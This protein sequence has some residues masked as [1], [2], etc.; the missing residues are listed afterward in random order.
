MVRIETREADQ[1]LGTVLM[2]NV[3]D[4]SGK[5]VLRKGT[6]LAR[7]DLDALVKL[8]RGQV[9]VAVLGE[10]DMRED[11]AALVLGTALCARHLEMTAPSGGR[12]NIKSMVDGVLQVDA[13]R[14]LHLNLVP[15]V[16]AATRG[17]HSVVGPN[18]DTNQVCTLKIVPY[19]VSRHELDRALV[20]AEARPGILEVR[21]FQP[22]RRVVMLLVGEEPVQGWLHDTYVPPTCLR[23]ER[24]GADLVEVSA[25][26]LED[27]S[28][29][30]GLARI[31]EEADLLV[32]ASQ[33]SIAHEEDPILMALRTV[34]A[35]AVV[36]GAPV[37]P[38][39]LLALA[40]LP[41]LPVLCLP[42]CARG[43]RRNVV[44]LVLPRLLLGDR[45]KREDVAAL[46]L[47]GLLKPAERAGDLT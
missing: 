23:L 4:E 6:W 24:L 30:D 45:L 47:G 2:H 39:N 46:G 16:A 3:A 15:G 26:S 5:R 20:L 31:R 8:G 34:G 25:V 44:D 41:G 1:T 35:Q 14:L 33:S 19:A 7:E 27:D 22:G 28:L 38:G 40:Y 42:G 9:L 12:V 29:G 10:D 13:D 43:M 36:S 18:Q 37:E 17:Q 21:P 11:E 32:I